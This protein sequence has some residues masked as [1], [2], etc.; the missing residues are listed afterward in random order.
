MVK[1]AFN[2]WK[3]PSTCKLDLNFREKLL[4][5]Y[6][7]SIVIHGSETWTFRKVENKDLRSFEM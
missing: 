1:A 6:I 2:K 5:C 3:T 7:W 4:K